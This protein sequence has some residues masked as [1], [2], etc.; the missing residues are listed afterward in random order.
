M[1]SIFERLKFIA[2]KCTRGQVIHWHY[3]L[4][5]KERGSINN[6]MNSEET[7][8]YILEHKCSVARFGDGEFQMIEHWQNGGDK[9]NFNVDTFQ[10][11]DPLLAERL[12]QVLVSPR[13]NL[14]VCIPYP[15]IHSE[16]YHGYDRMFFE[17]EWLGR[18]HLIKGVGLRQPLMGD[19]TFTRF[20]LHRKDITDFHSYIRLLKKVWDRVPIIFVEGEKS[21]LGVGNDLFDNA[22]SIQRII[23]PAVNAFSVY[24]EILSCIDAFGKKD[25]LYLLALGHTATVLAAELAERGYRAI[26]LGHVDI[27]YEWFR[28]GAKEKCPVP[29]KYVNEVHAGRDVDNHIADEDYNK[30]I[31][32]RIGS[33]I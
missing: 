2:W 21:R 30:Q 19:T 16:V 29:N 8:H 20:Y 32:A 17:R 9:T 6:L 15:M 27:E 25:C 7:I 24:D 31:I 13:D 4:S 10:S 26:D 22:S 14:L 33:N 11:F 28:M 5:H 12:H 3:R 18:S 23:C 1:N